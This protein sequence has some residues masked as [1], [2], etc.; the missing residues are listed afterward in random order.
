M[1][2]GVLGPLRVSDARG[3]IPVSGVKERTVLACLLARAGTAV[4]HDELVDALWPDDPPRTATKT[5]QAYV[6]RLRAILQIPGSPAPP[7]IVTEGRGYRLV[8]GQVDLDADRFVRLAELGRAALHEGQGARAAE[9]LAAALELWRG[10]AYA[11]FDDTVM[12]RAEARR[13]GALAITVREDWYDARLRCGDVDAVAADLEAF[14]TEN[15][16]REHAWAL[17]VRARAASGDQA[18]AL[19]A[20]ERAR[21]TLAEELGVDPGDELRELQGLVLAQDVS[22][23]PPVPALPAGL[24]APGRLLVARAGAVEQLMEGWER[25]VSGAALDVSLIGADG[26]GRWLVAGELARRVHERGGAVVLE[27]AAGRPPLLRIHDRRGCVARTADREPPAPGE[28]RLVVADASDD[29][30]AV[31]L[32]ALTLDE[33]ARLLHAYAPAATPAQV[34]AVAP[35]VLAVTTGTAA[36]V[37]DAALDLARSWASSRVARH[38]AAGTTGRRELDRDREDLATDVLEWSS[39]RPEPTGRIDQCPWRGLAAYGVDDRDWFVGREHLAAR[40]VAHVATEQS[41]LVVGSSGSGKSSLLAAGL[42]AELAAGALPDSSTWLPIVLRPGAHPMRAL[43]SAAVDGAGEAGPDRVADL[44]TRSLN[45]L[46]SAARILLVVDQLEECWTVCSDPGERTAFLDS[47]V[48]LAASPGSRTT[49]IAAVRADRAGDLAT[50]Q[51]FAALMSG[52]SVFVGPMVEGEL[53]RAIEAPASRAGLDLDV[54][55]ADTLVADTLREPGGLPLLSTALVALWE[56]RDGGRLSLAQ[57]AATGGVGAAVARMAEAAMD[58]LDPDAHRTARLLL[59]RLA[60]PGDGDSVTRRRVAVAELAALPDPRIPRC[61]EVFTDARLVT[62]SDGYVE[63]AHEALFRSWPRLRDWL[64]EDAAGRRVQQRLTQAAAEW[65]HEHRDPASLWSGARLAG[66]V[67]LAATRPDELT[68]LEHEFVEASSAR[69]TAERDAAVQQA[70]RARRQNRRLRLLLVGVVAA[71]VAALVAGLLATVAR[72]EAEDQR[73]T[74]TAQR[75]AATALTR[76]YL[77]DRL[78]TAVEAVRVEESPQTVGALLSTLDTSRQVLA[79]RGMPYRLLGMDAAP[80][81][82][83]AYAVSSAETIVAVDLESGTTRE[84]W[85][86]PGGRALDPRVSPDGSLL[87]FTNDPGN[88]AP[89]IEVI[90]ARDGRLAWTVPAQQWMDGGYDFTTGADRLAVA[91]PSG[92][93]VYRIGRDAPVET[94]P[95]RI[96]LQPQQLRRLADDRMLLLAG[97]FG[98]PARVVDLGRRRTEPAPGIGGRA[99]LS[100]DGTWAISQVADEEPVQRVDLSGAGRAPQPVGGVDQYTEGVV[101][102][103]GRSI[104]IAGG[105]DV[106]VVD[107]ETLQVHERLRGHTGSVLGL[108]A[109]ADSR[110][111]WTAGR[112]ADL[113]AWDLTGTRGLVTSTP[114]RAAAARGD[115]SSD[116]RVVATWT[117]PQN[118]PPVARVLDLASGRTLVGPF[119]GGAERR[120]PVSVALTPDGGTFLAAMV[121]APE[122]DTSLLVVDVPSGTVRQDVPMPWMVTGIAPAPDGRSAVVNGVGGVA[123]VDLSTGSVL[124]TREL[125]AYPFDINHT[126]DAA[127]SPDGRWVAVGRAGEALVLDTATLQTVGSWPL[128]AYDAITSLAWVDGG[129]LAYGGVQGRLGW[130]QLPAG[131]ALGEPVTISPGFVLDLAASPD[132]RHVAALGTDGEVGLW[133]VAT[134]TSLGTPLVP[135]QTGWGFLHLD[136]DGSVLLVNETGHAFGWPTSTDVLLDRACAIAGR[137]PTAAEWA[138]M[139]GDEPQRPTCDSRLSTDLLTS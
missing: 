28:L 44:L 47:L 23:R 4:T 27:D 93:V 13:L 37:R 103:D 60:G 139:H 12:C 8:E 20:L 89:R 83:T 107:A 66:A 138:A 104:V 121:A 118:A 115:A 9:S 5:L 91:T 50:H 81:G 131:T 74:A 3:E 113:I 49:V 73:R 43:V 57:Y 92:L 32:P 90:D 17:L 62:V 96:E 130:A 53:R 68:A 45:G 78:L 69:V 19:D 105:E 134:R 137:E 110:T 133:D 85:S 84:L 123:R 55:L 136:D 14:V 70:G 101:T 94:I 109:T 79:R 98:A 24:A 125:P 126:M 36:L 61:L 95:W 30:D 99:A 25:V 63:V 1:E 21:D 39:L 111:L 116:G 38:A 112:D 16:V 120:D 67:D 35:Q 100:P 108:A 52:R 117:P 64:G 114:V 40:L 15:P 31:H 97:G 77:A 56:R 106:S 34:E 87:A 124:S 48:D 132:G 80:G 135:P 82:R 127:S 59:T 71:L 75:L 22:L 58:E 86:E 51:A 6:A 26:A 29:A 102:R 119:P 2:V 54:G 129:V 11:G 41:L 122:A 10:P 65:E 33:V 128:P 7:L 42:L 46:G 18:G 76:D 88:R 72:R